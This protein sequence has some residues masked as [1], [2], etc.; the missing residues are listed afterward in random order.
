MPFSPE[1]LRFLRG[2]A[3]NNNK[4][5]FESH[6]AV[7]EGAVREPMRELI[8]EMDARMRRFAPEPRGRSEAVDVP[9]Q[10]RHPLLQGQ[11]AVQDARGV[12]VLSSPGRVEGRL[13]SPGRQ[14]RLLLSPPAGAV[15]GGWRALEAAAAAT[16]PVAR[17]DRRGSS[18]VRQDREGVAAEIRRAW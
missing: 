11:V 9:D 10:S 16:Q 8:E 17:R 3:K 2:L 15:D 18:G 14:C 7:Y 4:T 6:R 12:L 13:G 5:W 1:S